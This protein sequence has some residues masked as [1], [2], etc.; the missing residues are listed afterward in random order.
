[1]STRA[2]LSSVFKAVMDAIDLDLELPIT[3]NSISEGELEQ[4]RL[5]FAEDKDETVE[6]LENNCFCALVAY[7]LLN[8][9]IWEE[10][11][12]LPQPRKCYAELYANLHA[13]AANE[14]GAS[15]IADFL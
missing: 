8:E 3:L 6:W 10:V 9:L 2:K 4:L 15:G 5:L 11:W 1:M 13:I 12:P 14:Y 7:K